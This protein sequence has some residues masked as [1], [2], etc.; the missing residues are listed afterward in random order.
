MK[1][2]VNLDGGIL[3]V[4]LDEVSNKELLRAAR[5]ELELLKVWNGYAGN[6]ADVK[7]AGY[8]EENSSFYMYRFNSNETDKTNVIGVLKDFMLEVE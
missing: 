2:R 5:I 3:E 8:P 6:K 4:W 1:A 7:F